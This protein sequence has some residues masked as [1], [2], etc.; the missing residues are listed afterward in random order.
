MD[1]FKYSIEYGVKASFILDAKKDTTDLHDDPTVKRVEGLSESYNDVLEDDD[2]QIKFN[3]WM[4][5]QKTH[6]SD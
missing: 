6:N 4:I 3:S 1:P 5:L 2:F